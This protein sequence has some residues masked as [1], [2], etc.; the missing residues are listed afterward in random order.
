[1]QY[2][3]AVRLKNF[4]AMAGQFTQYVCPLCQADRFS[5]RYH[6]VMGEGK[7]L[8]LC[9]HAAETIHAYVHMVNGTRYEPAGEESP[10]MAATH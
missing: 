3:A 9:A 1:M 4:N 6:V 8:V 7:T 5:D 2:A 10:Y